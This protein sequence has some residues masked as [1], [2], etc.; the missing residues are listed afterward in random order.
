MEGDDVVVAYFNAIYQYSSFEQGNLRIFIAHFCHE[1][2]TQDGQDV[3]GGE[4]DLFLR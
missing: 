2:S 3:K 4:F 1:I